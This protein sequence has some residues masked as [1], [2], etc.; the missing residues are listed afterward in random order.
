MVCPHWCCHKVLFGTNRLALGK[1]QAFKYKSLCNRTKKCASRFNIHGISSK[2]DINEC[3]LSILPLTFK[4]SV[5]IYSD[6]SRIK[7]NSLV[8]PNDICINIVQ[9]RLFCCK[10]PMHGKDEWFSCK[11]V[12]NHSFQS[13][14]QGSQRCRKCC[15]SLSASPCLGLRKSACS[16][17]VVANYKNWGRFQHSDD[18]VEGFST[19][20]WLDH[21][22]C[23]ANTVFFTFDD[24]IIFF[25]NKLEWLRTR[26][27]V[28]DTE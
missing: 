23:W 6:K 21:L 24:L 16:L 25:Q 22:G 4:V 17:F 8:Q 10:C 19:F 26:A 5:C 18:F 27:K 7:Y 20:S 1:R 11:P 9:L 28:E 2:I 14:M 3:P 13:R 15:N 12:G